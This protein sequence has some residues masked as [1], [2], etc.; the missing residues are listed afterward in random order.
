M[1]LNVEFD[2]V[3]G[4]IIGRQSLSSIGEVFAEVRR[5]ESRKLV[6]LGRKGQIS[7][8]NSAVAAESYLEKNMGNPVFGVTIA[9]NQSIHVKLAG[10]FMENQLTGREHEGK[11]NRNPSANEVE[12]V[13]FTQ[14]LVDQVLKC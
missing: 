8:Q 6:I 2:E 5:E 3:R 1:G 9:T 12:V 4:R 13:P 10:N 11:F 7:N 14:K